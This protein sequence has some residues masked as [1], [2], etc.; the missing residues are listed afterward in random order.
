M[1]H[2]PAAADAIPRPAGSVSTKGARS[3]D[4]A[5]DALVAERLARKDRDTPASR[6][7]QDARLLGT[8]AAR[9]DLDTRVH[10][11]RFSAA[12]SMTSLQNLRAHPD[13]EDGWLRGKTCLEFGCGGLNPGGT[14]FAM[15]LQGAAR[16][17]ALDMDGIESVPL[18]CRALYRLA[19]AALVGADGADIRGTPREILARV[20]TF[21]LAKLA[22][23]DADGLDLDR[24]QFIQAPLEACG[25]PPESVDVV[26]SNSVFEHLADPEEVTAELARRMRSGG[27]A[28]HAI[29]GFDHRFYQ[30]ETV[31]PLAMLREE[32]DE[33][34]VYGCNRIRPLAFAE[35]FERHGLEVRDVLESYRVPLDEPQIASFAP[36]FRDVPLE[37]LEVARARFYLRKR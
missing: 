10:A 29:D 1:M 9:L 24:L 30:D 17:F 11:N 34:L 15:L 37:H 3:L 27:L 19:S 5:T 4:A 22:D 8:L 23:G 35:M 16:G 13:F 21:D 2:E 7:H 28:V 25:I 26:T 20:E 18:A 33:P 32:T 6:T 31:H 36:P 14:M 12:T